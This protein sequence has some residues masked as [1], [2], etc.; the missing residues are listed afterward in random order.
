M[1]LT[2][3]DNVST[4][5]GS[6]VHEFCV[7]IVRNMHPVEACEATDVISAIRTNGGRIYISCMQH[8]RAGAPECGVS[9]DIESAKAFLE[10]LRSQI[11][12]Q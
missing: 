11:E 6:A 10:I 8:G 9:L 4:Q 3:R 2:Y 5:T 7:K 12:R 1:N